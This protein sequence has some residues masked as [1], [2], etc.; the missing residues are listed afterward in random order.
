MEDKTMNKKYF[1]TRK[2]AIKACEERNKSNGCG[3]YKVFKMSKGTRKAGWY[4]VCSEME[5]LNTY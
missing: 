1:K 5:W 2:E 4:A 3:W